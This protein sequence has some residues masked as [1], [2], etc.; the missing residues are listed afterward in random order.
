MVKI[1]ELAHKIILEQM[2]INTAV[3]M[4][5]G[6]GNDTLFLAKISNQVFAFDIQNEAIQSTKYLLDENQ[7]T[8]VTL[9]QDNHLNIKSYINEKVDV[10]IYNLGYLP[11]GNKTIKTEASTTILSLKAALDLLNNQGL[12]LI[13]MYSH[14][15]DEIDQV[16]DFTKRLNAD[17]DCINY[18]VVNK[19]F[20]PQIV[21]IKK[22]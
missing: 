11:L 2:N 16:M 18:K 13:V 17:Y 5:C 20:C 4:T 9:I 7:I 22:G 19:E 10:F 1:T 12:I 8:N 14:N 3:D 21:T 15:Q 6:R